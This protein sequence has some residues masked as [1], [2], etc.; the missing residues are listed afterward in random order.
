MCTCHLTGA[1]PLHNHIWEQVIWKLRWDFIG[2]WAKDANTCVTL[3]Q[4]TGAKHQ[5]YE[6]N[7]QSR[8][9]GHKHS[10]GS[11]TACAVP[12]PSCGAA[13]SFPLSL[14]PF[15]PAGH[16]QQPWRS[17]TC[18]WAVVCPS[19]WA[20]RTGGWRCPS[21]TP[22]KQSNWHTEQPECILKTWTIEQQFSRNF[23]RLSGPLSCRS[24]WLE[25]KFWTTNFHNSYCIKCT[26][27]TL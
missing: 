17:G 10:R 6:V 25:H 19:D 1:H 2:R 11:Y 9:S 15:P 3:L 20:A 7:S 4:E 24:F 21:E 14:S 8:V 16:K 5:S 13:C 18:T 23:W 22:G 26:V 12:W 27:T